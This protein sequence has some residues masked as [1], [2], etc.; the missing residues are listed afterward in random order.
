LGVYVR[1]IGKYRLLSREEELDLAFRVRDDQDEEAAN[2]LVTANLRLVVKIARDFH[3][4]WKR[5]LLDLIQEG[6]LGL[7]QAVKKF[8]PNRG[9]KFSY[10]ASFWIKAYMMKFMMD[11]WRLVKVGTTQ[12][13]R[14]LFFNLSK[15]KEKL[16]AEG[17]VPEAKLVAERLDVEERD[18]T[19]MAQ[20]M[21]G[22]EISLHAPLR[23][24][25][26]DV[27]EFFLKDAGA[28]AEDR[29]SEEQRR[30][31]F[32][33]KLA[34]FRDRLTPREA[35]IFENRIMGDNPPILQAL[36]DKYNISRERVR[37]IQ[38]GIIRDV[39]EWSKNEI[40]NFEE[41]YADFVQ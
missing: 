22:G 16:R 13:Q 31:V 28:G 24:D 36:G 1:E 7:I 17:F 14:K 37:Q 33:K 39:E 21:E 27:Y 12:R 15:E 34:E 40:P 38:M 41:E 11:N 25:G 30:Q 3:R 8:D 32:V 35:D 18:V 6:N 26:E 5:S 9:V 19:E 2:R 20:R 23:D 4:H 10:Y 29:L